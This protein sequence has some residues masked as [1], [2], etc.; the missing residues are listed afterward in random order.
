[1]KLAALLECYRKRK[2]I[3]LEIEKKQILQRTR[4]CF[5]QNNDIEF[6]SKKRLKFLKYKKNKKSC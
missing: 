4:N 1:M 6:L 5:V 3:R 2:M